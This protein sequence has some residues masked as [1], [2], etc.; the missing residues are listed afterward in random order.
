[1][2]INKQISELHKSFF[3]EKLAQ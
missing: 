2:T 3:T 1:M